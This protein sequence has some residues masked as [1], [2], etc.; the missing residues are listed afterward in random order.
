MVACIQYLTSYN[1]FIIANMTL[2]FKICDN[3][4]VLF[5][6]QKNR[7]HCSL[8]TILSRLTSAYLKLQHLQ[9]SSLYPQ[10]GVVLYNIEVFCKNMRSSNQIF[11]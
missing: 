4:N 5:K 6:E 1:F 11:L 10:A 3:R 9:K 2:I 8:G 7:S